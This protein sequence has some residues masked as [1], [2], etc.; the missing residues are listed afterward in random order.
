MAQAAAARSRTALVRQADRIN[1]E[2]A[3]LHPDAHL[4]LNFSSPLER[5][6]ATILSAQTTDHQLNAVT[7]VL[8][9]RYRTAA[10]YAAADLAKLEQVIL[11]T[12]FFR[13]KAK[14]LIALAQALRERFGGEVPDPLEELV[15]L[16]GV[17]RKTA[18]V[19][20][21]D[22]FGK[23]SLVVDTHVARLAKR[24]GWTAQRDRT[25]SSASGLWACRRYRWTRSSAR[26]AR[27]VTSNGT[28]GPP[29]TG[30]GRAGN[31]WRLQSGAVR[32]SRRSR[33][34]A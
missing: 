6:V 2:L 17:G 5:L 30:S 18:N 33:C 34:T 27:G 13:T 24:F 16:P 25:R 26:P 29:P 12:G 1:R 7:R 10:D 4:E 32:R 31:S 20:L 28:S 19:V 8:F 9:A 23:P 3:R 11:P 14:N 22:A 15:T 21:G